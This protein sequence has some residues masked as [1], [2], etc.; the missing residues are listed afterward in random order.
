MNSVWKYRGV[1][2]VVLDPSVKVR[3]SDWQRHFDRRV[4]EN[5]ARREDK[6]PEPIFLTEQA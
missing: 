3:D 6:K 2:S 4:A 5:I 1:R